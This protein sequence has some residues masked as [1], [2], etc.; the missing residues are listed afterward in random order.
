MPAQR[1]DQIA[2]ETAPAQGRDTGPHLGVHQ[3]DRAAAGQRPGSARDADGEVDQGGRPRGSAGRGLGAVE[4]QG[5]AAAGR[6]LLGRRLG[7]DRVF[8]DDHYLQPLQ[9]SVPI[10]GRGDGEGGVDPEGGATAGR[11]VQADVGV[12]GLGDAADDGQAKAGAFHRLGRGPPLG[13][14]FE[15]ALALFLGDARPRVAHAEADPRLARA[16][17]AL[18]ALGGQQHAAAIGELHRIAGQVEQHLTQPR[19]V[20]QD[21]GQAWID[22]PGDLQP[23]GVGARA[24]DLGH[25]LQQ[26]L[27]IDRRGMQFQGAGLQPRQVQHLVDQAQQMLAGLLQRGDI[28]ALGGVQPRAGQEPRHAQHAIQRRA[29]FVAQ[30]GEQ[31]VARAQRDRTPA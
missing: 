12:H 20:G 18:G 10:G 31:I 13:E 23:L 22:R 17:R 24:H 7:E 6:H 16:R 21:V 9:G 19:L 3:H 28:A 30:R 26:A 1:L 4:D 25:A 27:Q 29:E 2:F 8:R 14:G 15:D 11:A 5:L